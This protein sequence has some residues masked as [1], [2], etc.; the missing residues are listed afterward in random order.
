MNF[1]CYHKRG[2][3]AVIRGGGGIIADVFDTSGIFFR[4]CIGEFEY[5]K[6]ITRRFV[7]FQ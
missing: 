1:L 6:V 7:L 4:V 5:V 3:E 2:F